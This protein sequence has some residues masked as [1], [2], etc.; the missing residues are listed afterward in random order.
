MMGFVTKDDYT[1][2]RSKGLEATC[3][4]YMNLKFKAD[5]LGD[6]IIFA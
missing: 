3:G 2:S 4:D 6:S 5:T 1:T